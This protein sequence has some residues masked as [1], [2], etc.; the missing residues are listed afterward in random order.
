MD[1]E[2]VKD[3]RAR[4]NAITEQLD[5]TVRGGLM[6]KSTYEL[7]SVLEKWSGGMT[8]VDT[9]RASRKSDPGQT[10]NSIERQEARFKR[11]LV[12]AIIDR[13]REIANQAMGD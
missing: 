12:E 5:A 7:M 13:A 6:E 1:A 9:L 3:N 11:L 4:L 2:Q 10:F 8:V